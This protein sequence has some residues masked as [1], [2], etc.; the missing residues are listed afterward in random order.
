MRPPLT[1]CSTCP[2]YDDRS[3]VDGKRA[4]LCRSPDTAATQPQRFAAIRGAGVLDEFLAD[5]DVSDEAQD[6]VRAWLGRFA[7]TLPTEPRTIVRV[8]WP[9]VFG[10]EDWCGRHPHMKG[11]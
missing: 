3:P 10:D 7:K 5:G 8:L 1:T 11:G 2:L 4:G 6:E 9:I